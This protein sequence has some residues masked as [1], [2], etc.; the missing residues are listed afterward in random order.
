MTDIDRDADGKA[1]I[2]TPADL[3][4]QALQLRLDL[5]LKQREVADRMGCSTS[6]ISKVENFHE[7]DGM[8]GTRISVI[9]ALSDKT[10][11]GPLYRQVEEQEK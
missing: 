5:G 2:A 4:D 6:T 7:G 9:E 1:P 3:A 10:V 8:V 11:E